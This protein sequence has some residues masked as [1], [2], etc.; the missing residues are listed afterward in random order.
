MAKSKWYARYE[1]MPTRWVEVES[2][3]DDQPDWELFEAVHNRQD[4]PGEHVVARDAAWQNR[5]PGAS[6]MKGW[7]RQRKKPPTGSKVEIIPPVK[8]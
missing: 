5:A 7:L 4:L 2:E 1:E 6:F 3:N 8:R